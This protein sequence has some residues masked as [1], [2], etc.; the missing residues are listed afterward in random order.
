MKKSVIKLFGFL[1]VTGLVLTSCSR[2]DDDDDVVDDDNDNDCNF[3]NTSKNS[4][5]LNCTYSSLQWNCFVEIP[6]NDKNVKDF[7]SNKIL[8]SFVTP[9]NY[10]LQ[11]NNF[12]DINQAHDSKVDSTNSIGMTF[13]K[14]AF[15]EINKFE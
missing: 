3:S 11:K 15:E 12:D 1:A 14:S 4:I 5:I 9:I 8:N 10:L 13:D 7:I 6:T 2:G